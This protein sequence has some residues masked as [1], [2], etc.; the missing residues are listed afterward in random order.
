[1]NILVH[2]EPFG[3]NEK[4]DKGLNRFVQMDNK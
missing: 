1:M 2:I 3:Y 4:K